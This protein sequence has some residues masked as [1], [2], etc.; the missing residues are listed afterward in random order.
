MADLAGAEEATQ[1]REKSESHRKAAAMYRSRGSSGKANYAN[2]AKHCDKLAQFYE[3]AAKEAEGV[4]S[5][6]A[7]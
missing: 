4:A 1:L 7:K 3:D 6:L 5:E 2:V